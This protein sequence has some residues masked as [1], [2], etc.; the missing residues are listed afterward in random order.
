MTWLPRP[1][2]LE[3]CTSEPLH[4]FGRADELAMLDRALVGGEPSVVAFIGP[5]GQGKTAIVQHWLRPFVA[6]DRHADGVFLWSFYRGKDAD[7]CLRQLFGYAEGIG[8]AGSVRQLL[9]RSSATATAPRALGV[10]PGRRGGGAAR[11]RRL[12][13]ALRSSRIGTVGGRIG[14]RAVTGCHCAY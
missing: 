9:C 11:Q 14:V 13:R 12:V 2:H 4:F 8:G 10:D 7:V 1:A 3:H 6:G 5:G